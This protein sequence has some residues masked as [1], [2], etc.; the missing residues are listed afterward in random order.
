[1]ATLKIPTA[2]VF[3]PLLPPARYKGAYGGRG[4][5]KSHFFAEKLIED[6]MA[7]PGDFGEGLRS[8]CIREVQKDLA[9][10][11][12][13]L[14]EMKLKAFKLGEAQGFKVFRELI[15]TPGDGIIIFKGMNDYTAESI[16]SLE[17]FKRGWWEE[18]HTATAHSVQLYRPTLR[19]EGA[20]RWFS[21]NPR[22]KLDPVDLLFR[23]P[24]VPT[25]SVSV[26]ANWRDN[27]FFTD[28]LEQERLDCL[29]INPDQ[30]GHIWRS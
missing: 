16:K 7:E 20:E 11:A 9:Q 14:L 30:Y 5:G 26:E 4:S 2:K 1:M 3:I 10:S 24:E 21:W 23:G 12:K 22:R 19:A 13:Q 28:E 27:T 17:G 18:A 15:S 8:V 29:R 6:S 25:G